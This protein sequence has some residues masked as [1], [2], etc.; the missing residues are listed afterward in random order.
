[1]PGVNDA[2]E[3]VEEILELA[4]EAGART[5][6]GV[7]LHLRGEVRGIWFDWLRQYRPDLV[8]RYEALYERRAYLPRPEQERLSRMARGGR[9]TG[10]ARRIRDEARSSDREGGESRRAKPPRRQGNLFPA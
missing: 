3:Q 9:D 8:P 1:M 6:G 7:G 10:G 2:P 4:G 5:I